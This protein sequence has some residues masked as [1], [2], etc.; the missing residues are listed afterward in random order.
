MA[1]EKISQLPAGAPAQTTDQVPIARSGANFY[2]TVS[3]IIAKFAAAFGFNAITSGNNTGQTLTVG[4]GSTLEPTGT[5]IIEANL[6]EAIVAASITTIGG[7]VPVSATTDTTW[8]TKSVTMPATGG[9]FRVLVSYGMFYITSNSGSFVAW[10]DDGTN[11]FATSQTNQTGSA[12]SGD[13]QSASSVSPVT[14]AN[15][16]NVTFTAKAWTTSA[17]M[18]VKAGNARPGPQ[19]SWLNVAIIPS[20]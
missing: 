3:D 14:Y 17:S 16:A 11:Q 1:N 18:T 7:D 4:N 10:V 20:A 13:G 6:I 5:G 2:L 19:N 15:G 8:A 12:T 9:P